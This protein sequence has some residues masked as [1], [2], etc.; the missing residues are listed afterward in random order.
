MKKLII[1]FI[2]SVLLISCGKSNQVATGNNSVTGNNSIEVSSSNFIGIYDLVRMESDDCGASIRIV[3][4]CNGVKLLS[5]NLGPEEFCNINLGESIIRNRT[6]TTVTQ[7]GNQLQSIVRILE[8]GRNSPGRPQITFSN[9]L[10]LSDDGNTL[11]KI[12][13]LKSRVSRCL[14][15]KR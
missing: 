12:S 6:S 15:Q 13:N 11:A 8:D 5:N 3:A 4:D 14:Y 2:F 1:L 10:T 9:T 7:Q